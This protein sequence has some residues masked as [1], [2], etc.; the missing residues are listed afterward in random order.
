[1]KLPQIKTFC[2]A[3]LTIRRMKRLS[4]N[5]RKSASSL[6]D[7]RLTSRIYGELKKVNCRRKN[8]TENRWLKTSRDNSLK[9]K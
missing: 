6:S 1:M 5:G 4:T 3:K 2:T 8:S 7:R 9:Y